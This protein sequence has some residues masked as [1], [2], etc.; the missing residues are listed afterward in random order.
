MNHTI[1]HISL[2][3]I[4]Y[5]QAPR[6]SSAAFA[7]FVLN[8]LSFTKSL[9]VTK[10]EG[11]YELSYPTFKCLGHKVQAVKPDTKELDDFL[12]RNIF[13]AYAQF[14]RERP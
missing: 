3:P 2:E 5:K 13:K 9:I 6:N 1:G 12:Q 8:G 4:Y 10:Y 7:N 11:V 14:L